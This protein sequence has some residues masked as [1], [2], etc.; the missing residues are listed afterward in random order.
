MHRIFAVLTVTLIVASSLNA[1]IIKGRIVVRDEN[2]KVRNAYVPGSH[3]VIYMASDVDGRACGKAVV[4]NTLDVAALEIKPPCSADH[5]KAELVLNPEDLTLDQQPRPT[6]L[7]SCAANENCEYVMTVRWPRTKSREERRAYFEKGSNLA[8]QNPTAAL[9]YLSEASWGNVEF[10]SAAVT[11][12]EKQG[13]YSEIV[14]LL[15]ATDVASLEVDETTRFKF[16]MRQANAANAAKDPQRALKAATSALEI[17]PNNQQAPEIALRTLV[18]STNSYD[19][20]D[21]ANAI[22]SDNDLEKSFK[23]F[24]LTWQAKGKPKATFSDTIADEVSYSLD[25]FGLTREKTLEKTLGR[26]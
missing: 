4:T 24:Y 15:E 1:A 25:R 16:L 14:S 12:L 23:H 20:A 19:P 13:S 11:L 3:H 21:I 22:R 18:W 26:R 17:Y 5:L 7:P 6:V 2:A 9:A 8:S 10:T